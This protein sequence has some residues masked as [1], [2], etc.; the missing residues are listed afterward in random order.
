MSAAAAPVSIGTGFRSFLFAVG[1]LGMLHVEIFAD[2]E[3]DVMR[4]I[5]SGEC[6][7]DFPAQLR[8]EIVGQTFVLLEKKEG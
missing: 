2:S 4:Y 7:K 3:R 5:R 8:K 1:E 6:I